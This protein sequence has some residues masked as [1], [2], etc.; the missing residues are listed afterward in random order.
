M[1]PNRYPQE[2][3]SEECDLVVLGAEIALGPA[4]LDFRE[5]LYR[6]GDSAPA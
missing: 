5:V 4:D 1:R 3:D 2:H 6:P